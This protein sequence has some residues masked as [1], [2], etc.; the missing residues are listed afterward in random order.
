MRIFENLDLK[1]LDKRKITYIISTVLVLASIGAIFG[2]GIQYGI[3]FRG[4]KEYVVN[5]KDAVQVNDVRKAL[6]QPLGGV[7]EVKIYGDANTLLIRTDSEVPNTEEVLLG[8]LATEFAGNDFIREKAD[9]V[10]PRF[11]EDLKAGAASSVFW[12]I[13]VI[14]GYIFI[15]FMNVKV[16]RKWTFSVGAVAALLHD[17]IITLGIFTML[18][19]LLPVSRDIDQNLIAAF[20]TI[21]GY[22]LNDT[23]VVF[24]RIR[25]YSNIY[26]TDTFER[27]VNRSISS[28][29]S[30]TV[31]TSVTTLFVVLVLFIFGGEV[32]RGLSLALIVGITVG[33]YS[34]IFVAS[35]LVVDLNTKTETVRA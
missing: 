26:K 19:G 7:P 31:I 12:A 33:T 18:A 11:A 9:V 2:R 25:E 8:A 4:G 21:V 32:L 29:L 1:L 35:A 24:D 15:R 20:L 34:S 5:F 14:F 27:M 10:G 23:V 28:T 30:R 13:V 17:V 6:E 3:D 16:K 22:S